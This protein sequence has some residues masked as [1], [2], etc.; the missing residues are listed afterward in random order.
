MNKNEIIK[1]CNMRADGYTLQAIADEMGCSKQ[2]V[3]QS[4]KHFFELG[5]THWYTNSPYPNLVNEIIS[6]YNKLTAFSKQINIKHHRIY[7]IV[8][9]NAKVTLDEAIMLSD[10]LGKDI[11]YLFEKSAERK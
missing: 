2:Y 8:N 1:V 3:H 6:Q 7:N 9:G 5:N 10:I 4:L 11:R